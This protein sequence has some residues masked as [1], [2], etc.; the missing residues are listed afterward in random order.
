MSHDQPALARPARSKVRYGQWE[1]DHAAIALT[2]ASLLWANIEK[3]RL[4][5]E[6]ELIYQD[7][8]S[9]FT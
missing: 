1:D 3:Y 2:V 8:V 4:E 9:E 7:T 5:I 6:L